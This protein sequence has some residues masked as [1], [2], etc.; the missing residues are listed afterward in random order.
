VASEGGAEM[1]A[2][3]D[4][5]THKEQNGGATDIAE[6]NPAE[7]R[8]FLETVA[9][10]VKAATEGMTDP[11]LL[12]MGRVHPLDEKG[13]VP[14]R[15]KL[16]DVERMI[17]DA[18]AFSND[19]HN[20][21]IEGRT[22]RAGLRGKQRGAVEDS[23]AVFALVADDDGDK[24]KTIETLPIKPTLHVESSPGNTHPWFFLAKA[25]P[26]QEG[27][28]LGL[29]LKAALRGD[30][31]TG[32]I[33]QPY[34]VSGTVNYPTQ[35]KLE[36][37]RVAVPTRLLGT[38]QAYTIEEFNTAFPPVADD[39]LPHAS[40]TEVTADLILI[41][42]AVG[43]IQ[44]DDLE[45]GEWNKIG[46]AI[47]AASG[48]TEAGSNIF[49][50][51][52]QKSKKYNRRR[53]AERWRHY[54]RS[55]PT[56][57]GFGTLRFL[58][59]E[60]DP[61][62]ERRLEDKLVQEIFHPNIDPDNKV[63]K[64]FNKHRVAKEPGAEQAAR[65]PPGGEE[66][67]N[68]SDL[69]QYLKAHP[70]PQ[71]PSAGD[72]EPPCD[73]QHKEEDQGAAPEANPP[74][75]SPGLI[76]SS[77]E[78]IANFKPPDYLIEGLLQRRFLYSMTAQTN[79]GKTTVALRL[80]VQVA[81]GLPL[82]ELDIESGKVLFFAGENPD[83]VRMRWIKLCEEMSIDPETEQVFW[84][85]GTYSIR[86]LRSTINAQT[87]A[88]GPFALI[89]IDSAAAYFEGTD[90]NSNTELGNYAR[91]LRTLVDIY[92]GPTIIV[93]CHP[94]KNANPENLI[95]RG[96]G[97]FLN[98]VDGNL[99]LMPVSDMSKV[100]DLHWHGKFRGPDFSPIPFMLTA[101]T[102]ER[103]KD[104]KGRL[105]WTVTAKPMK[106]AERKMAEDL[107]QV[108]QQKLLDAMKAKEGASL[109]DL[110][111]YCGWFYKNN[112]EP[113]KSLVER[114][115][116]DLEAKRLVKKEHGHWKLTKAGGEMADG[117]DN[118]L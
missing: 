61:D 116:H 94:V 89:I 83:D 87:K 25:V 55:P 45:W 88:Y 84:V 78:F 37:G 7:V 80:A 4:K 103:I 98:E 63:L 93:L 104:S 21:Y 27:V 53:T 11:G 97:A 46:M 29:A 18:I 31:D 39:E 12:Q 54:F 108:N 99:V 57:I 22:V 109:I 70:T 48:G 69:V 8:Q 16:G 26:A 42:A 72:P 92:G 5:Q 24:G 41:N 34:R 117:P 15:Y 62:W 113:N 114:I 51:L 50:E 1:N 107:G 67:D 71:P 36:R 79:S 6:T 76:I 2:F 3:K 17:A 75:K 111:R 47:W 13:Y 64:F 19:G 96:G 28:A 101:G 112:G 56:R 38:T 110:A 10:L 81:L 105:I 66:N 115:M 43:A 65:P 68:V 32:T 60:A 82:G 102:S 95:P 14:T 9:A 77:R 40:A 90:E 74:P 73:T 59:T 91:M 30:Y 85:A 44:N 23:V 49:D 58:A 118:P 35:S 100:V 106:A 33:T 86:K 52:S 20:V